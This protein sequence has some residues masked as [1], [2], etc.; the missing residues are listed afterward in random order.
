MFCCCLVALLFVKFRFDMQYYMS[1]V[2]IKYLHEMDNGKQENIQ[3]ITK[4][5]FSVASP[6]IILV[7]FLSNL[8][9]AWV[10]YSISLNYG[11]LILVKIE[12][13]HKCGLSNVF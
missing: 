6:S 5:N 2:I 9:W 10:V 4:I 3:E 8:A 11:V 13:K 7:M 12:T 1:S